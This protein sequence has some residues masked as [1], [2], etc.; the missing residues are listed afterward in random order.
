MI[1]HFLVAHPLEVVVG[2]VVLPF[3]G[4][5]IRWTIWAFSPSK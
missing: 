1:Q 2:V 4:H 5:I 3:V